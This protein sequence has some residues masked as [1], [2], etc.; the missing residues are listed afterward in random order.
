MSVRIRLSAMM[1]LQYMM[2]AV[3]WVATGRVPGQTGVEATLAILDSRRIRWA[4]LWPRPVHDRRPALC[5]SEGVDGAERR[6]AV[7]FFLGPGR[8][9]HGLFVILLLA[10]LC[11]MPTWSLTN[12]IAMA[13]A[14]AEKFPQIV[15]SAPSA[16]SASGVF[17]FL[18]LRVFGTAIDGR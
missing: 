15:C 13:N 14:P 10:M 18:A 7:L 1:F 9:A 6:C 2:F 17:G 3:W 12:A 4:A 11:Y 5:Q 8:T 16:G